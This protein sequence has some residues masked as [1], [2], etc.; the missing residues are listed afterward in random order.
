MVA[1]F[2]LEVYSMWLV[3]VMSHISSSPPWQHNRTIE[4]RHIRGSSF[5]SLITN[6]SMRQNKVEHLEME[7]EKGRHAFDIQ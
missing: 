6:I 7:K 1:F 5:C 2:W 3:G 4:K